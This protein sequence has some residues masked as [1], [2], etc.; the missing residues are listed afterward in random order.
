MID[1]ATLMA[2][3]TH[4]GAIV[5]LGPFAL[6]VAVWLAL[7]AG[8]REAL[9]W[10][11]CVAG[12]GGLMALLKI[13]FA[14]CDLRVFHIHS[15]S[16]HAAA[17]AIAYGGFTVIAMAGSRSLRA[18][19]FR[20][21]IALWVL[22]IGV[23]R[24]AVRAHTPAEVVAGLFIGGVGVAVFACLY[25]GRVRPPYALAGGA[26]LLVAVIALSMPSQT[27]VLEPWLR[28]LASLLEPYRPLLC[29]VTPS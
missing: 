20:V 29:G 26:L 25:R 3:V 5:L 22:L 11:A 21:A 12:V 23:S 7:R 19:L 2:V 27:F 15:A 24:V 9:L 28:L 8:R 13:Y 18:N 6:A 17:S 1:I 4:F 16:G 14:A 10:C